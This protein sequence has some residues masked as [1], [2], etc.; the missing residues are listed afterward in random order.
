MVKSYKD[1]LVYQRAYE[2]SLL[3]HKLS[4][5]F[6]KNGQYGGIADQLRRASKSIALNI[7]EGYGRNYVTEFKRF[8]KISLG[9]NNEVLVLLDYCKD[10]GYLI[11]SDHANFAD[12]YVQVG[13]M[14]HKL[15]QVWK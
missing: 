15:I 13:K 10:L 14:L 8:L 1:L 5:D 12:Q 9:S 7:A 4:L 11:P 6:P 3:I 2:Q